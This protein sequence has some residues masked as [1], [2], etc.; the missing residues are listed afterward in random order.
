MFT[1]RRQY[2]KGNRILIGITGAAPGMGV[3]H[4][5]LMLAGYS[6]A[7]QR[8]KTAVVELG[9][10]HVLSGIRDTTGRLACYCDYP[11][12]RMSEV[13]KKDYEVIV[14][15]CGSTYYRIRRELLYCDKKLVVGSLVPWRRQEYMDFI[16]EEMGED[17][18]AQNMILLT[19]NGIKSDKKEFV[20]TVK[21]PVYDIPYVPDPFHIG[22]DQYGFVQHFL[23]MP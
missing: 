7:I 17:I 14:F 3:T 15:D 22:K 11:E 10:D 23:N 16:L 19:A 12:N 8:R 20:K 1:E 5:T 13:L 18:Q 9:G 21:M 6:A 2:T 4:L